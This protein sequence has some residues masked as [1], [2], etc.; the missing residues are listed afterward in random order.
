[1]KFNDGTEGGGIVYIGDIPNI[2]EEILVDNEEK[3]W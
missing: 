2:M 1:M 3:R